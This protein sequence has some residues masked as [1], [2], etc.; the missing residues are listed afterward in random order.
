MGTVPEGGKL[1]WRGL[2]PLGVKTIG[3]LLI[4]V[5]VANFHLFFPAVTSGPPS[6]SSICRM[7]LR[8]IG[9]AVWN[10]REEYGVLP[11]VC[12]SDADGKRMHSWRVLILPFL[13]QQGLH[14]E[15][16]IDEAWNGKNNLELLQ[17]VPS[18]YQCLPYWNTPRGDDVRTSYVML[19]TK[20]PVVEESRKSISGDKGEVVLKG[21]PII[22]HLGLTQIPW[23]EPGDWAL[24]SESVP[25]VAPHSQG[26]TVLRCASGEVTFMEREEL[27]G[28]LE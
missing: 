10:Y 12:V 25:S 28:L 13:D 6:A 8:Q 19:E 22:V 18:V 21:G 16:R 4:L 26:F 20:R 17:Q 7:N 27:M 24:G 15:Y 23:M 1:A 2:T 11:P 3:F 5:L 9:L 14:D